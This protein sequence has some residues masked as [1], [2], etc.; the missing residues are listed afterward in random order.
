M[1]SAELN[2]PMLDNTACNYD[3]TATELDDSCIYEEGSVAV[4]EC[5]QDD[6]DG[7]GNELDAL[8][9]A[10]TTPTMMLM[11]SATDSMTRGSTKWNLQRSGDIYDMRVL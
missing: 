6:G 5:P 8:G 11:A 10:P 2:G 9:D 3:P 1:A 4:T 7:N